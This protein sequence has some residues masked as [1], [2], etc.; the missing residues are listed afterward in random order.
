M[1]FLGEVPMSLYDR[2][3]CLDLK[4]EQVRDSGDNPLIN[5][6]YRPEYDLE[7][8]SR[9]FT[10]WRCSMLVN[11]TDVDEKVG[12][13]SVYYDLMYVLGDH[14]LAICESIPCKSESED[15]YGVT[16]KGSLW[17]KVYQFCMNRGM[18]DS[19]EHYSCIHNIDDCKRSVKMSDM[20]E[21]VCDEVT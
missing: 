13:K 5:N 11:V 10:L 9:I 7:N 8:C 1:A 17:F 14:A 16:W 4:P 19:D 12:L 15:D 21:E 6:R 2:V 3:L 18:P 20:C